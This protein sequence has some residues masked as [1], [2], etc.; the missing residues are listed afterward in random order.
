MPKITYGLPVYGSSDADLTI[1]Q[2]FLDRCHTRRYISYPMC[3]YKLLEK[4]DIRIF[5]KI[6][7]Q[8][9]HPL[10]KYLP[11]IKPSSR[12]LRQSSSLRPKVNT[13]RFENSFVNRLIFKGKQGSTE[14]FPKIEVHPC[15]FWEMLLIESSFAFLARN[16]GSKTHIFLSR[17]P[18]LLS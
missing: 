18:S 15:R 4:C 11:R 7:K 6:C 16:L 1:I 13:E 10:R 12:R 8:E 14:N 5:K 9:L 3:I 17:P 2:C